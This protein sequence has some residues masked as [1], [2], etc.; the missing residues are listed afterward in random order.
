MELP[1]AQIKGVP[2]SR[3]FFMGKGERIVT[4]TDVWHGFQAK[5]LEEQGPLIHNSD[6]ICYEVLRGLRGLFGLNIPLAINGGLGLRLFLTSI[7]VQALL[8][9]RYV[10]IPRLAGLGYSHL[11]VDVDLLTT[12]GGFGG[13]KQWLETN[14]FQTTDESQV[15]ELRQTTLDRLDR[16][17]SRTYAH[18]IQPDRRN[19]TPMGVDLVTGMGYFSPNGKH[20][21]I[22]QL[23]GD[24]SIGLV[25]V[26]VQGI[27]AVRVVA[28]S[29]ITLK[30]KVRRRG[31]EI[32]LDKGVTLGGRKVSAK[33]HESIGPQITRLDKRLNSLAFLMQVFIS[34]NGVK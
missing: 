12:D 8:G 25:T 19:K 23:D 14:G 13:V 22:M 20:H 16:V 5:D 9:D 30:N 4:P 11:M 17:G 32:T 26:N 15:K 31:L 29:A 6:Q 21:D 34:G 2:L 33:E 7:E 3:G 1:R 18:L 28:P 10:E 27:G 24:E